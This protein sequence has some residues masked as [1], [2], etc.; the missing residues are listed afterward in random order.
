MTP[1][2]AKGAGAPPRADPP[3]DGRHGLD[4]LAAPASR[5]WS[6]AHHHGPGAPAHAGGVR[7]DGRGD[8]RDRL[9]AD[10]LPDRRGARDHPAQG[11]GAGPHAGGRHPVLRAR[12]R[13]RRDRVVR[14]AGH[15]GI[16]PD[17][18]AGA[19]P[20]RRR[21]AV[22]PRRP[23]HRRQVAPHP[24]APLPA[25][26]S[27]WTPAVTSSATPASAWS[28]PGSGSASGRWSRRSS[29]QVGASG[30][31]RCTCGARHPLTAQHRLRAA[32]QL[33]SFGFGHSMA[34]VGQLLSQQGD[35]MVVGRWL[36]AA[37]AGHLR[38]G[39]QPHGDAGHRLRPD[40][41]PGAVPG[42]GA[43]AGR[44]RIA[45]PTRTSARSPSSRYCRSR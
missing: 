13:A 43:G 37:A 38:A 1:R 9:L 25:S 18:R 39:V 30:G 35:N 4:L 15:R 23:Q 19:G 28:W 27:P 44:A 41:Q 12:T 36:G 40:R 22:P 11:S 33:L 17:A 5:S 16:L 8:R 45:S 3:R 20:A 6:S 29:A 14:G 34:Q 32:R 21:L 24:G 31:R 26:T 42:H 10:R 7:P 2:S